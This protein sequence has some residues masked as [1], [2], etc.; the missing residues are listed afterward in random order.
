MQRIGM[1]FTNLQI[2]TDALPRAEDL[3]MQ[4]MAEVYRR[5][6]LTQLLLIFG[7]LFLLSFIPQLL[8]I[9]P[10]LLKS[11]LLLI[12]LWI[13]II[14]SLVTLLVVKQIKVKA[15]A[16]R[17]HDIAY[18]SGLF[19]RKTT[20]LLFSRVQ[21]VEVSSGPLQRRFD[22]ATLKFFTAGGSS[23]DLKIEGLM[24]DDAEKLREFILL[25]GVGDRE[26]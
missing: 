2:D 22:L 6:S 11:Q 3:H 4:P 25:R 12:P 16:L 26:T 5:E 15:Y 23:V 1:A 21:H 24:R 7:P 18:R 17:D 13:L 19:W 14:G 8:P 10:P 9:T 20:L